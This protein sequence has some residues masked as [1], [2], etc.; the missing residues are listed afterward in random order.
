MFAAL[1][2]AALVLIYP[3]YSYRVTAHLLAKDASEALSQMQA[4]NA[5]M[6]RE[7]REQ[8]RQRELAEQR[9]RVAAVRVTGVA[10]GD[11]PVVMAELGSASVNESE[12]RLCQ[13]SAGWLKRP[14][15]GV[16]LRI[17]ARNGHDSS[18]EMGRVRC[19]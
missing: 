19:G 11:Q 7:L 2:S 6:Q 4:E 1:L 9:R 15:H 10:E 16:T 5:R 8:R 13:L 3:W 14:L 18:R 12:D 17:H